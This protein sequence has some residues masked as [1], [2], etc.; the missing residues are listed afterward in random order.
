MT[1]TQVEKFIK[2]FSFKRNKERLLNLLKTE[3]EYVEFI[4][5]SGYIYA[6]KIGEADGNDVMLKVNMY[7]G[8]LTIVDAFIRSIPGVELAIA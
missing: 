7:N 1:K 4:E 5:G 2:H 8:E 6:V 3:G